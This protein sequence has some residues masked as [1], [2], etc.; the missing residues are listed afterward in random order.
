VL[1]RGEQTA[2][3]LHWAP[4]SRLQIFHLCRVPP[5]QLLPIEEATNKAAKRGK[6]E[7]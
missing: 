7:R 4:A 3:L 5:K 6:T 2:I 1:A